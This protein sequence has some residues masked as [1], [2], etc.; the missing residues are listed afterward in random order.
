[1][2]Q[3]TFGQRL[4]E[5]RRARGISQR[6]LAERVDVDFTYLSKLENDRFPPPSAKTIAALAAELQTDADEL[7]V[8]AGKLPAD[9]QEALMAS[10]AALKL[11]RVLADDIQS[12]TD[13]EYYLRRRRR[14]PRS[15]RIQDSKG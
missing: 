2:D 8:L 6:N 4:R 14:S 3:V 10:P 7:S 13:W 9:L 5:L 12:G 15:R 1:M 11:L